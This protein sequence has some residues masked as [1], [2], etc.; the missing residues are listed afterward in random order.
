MTYSRQSLEKKATY[1]PDIQGLRAVAALLVATY[2]IWFGRVSGGV[3]VFFAV[4]AF[5]ITT[6][7]LRQLDTKGRVDFVAFWGGLA[8][9]LLPAAMLVLFTVALAS[10][11][12]LPRTLWDKTIEQMVAS[13]FYVE[14]WQLAHDAVDYLAQGRAASPVQHYW[15]L[16]TQGQ[17]YVLW[18]IVFAVSIAAAA[19]L[20]AK[21]RTIVGGAFAGIFIASF[22]LSIVATRNNQTFT[23][24]NTFARLW[25][26]CLGA[27]LAFQPR[28]TL[29]RHLRVAFGWIGLVGIIVC[30]AIFQVSRVFPG[31]AA[32]WPVGCAVLIV[33]AGPSGSRFGA[34]RLLASR[35]LVYIGGISYGLYLWHWPA[36]VFYRW[37]TDF[38]DVGLVAGLGIVTASMALAAVSTRL[39]ENPLRF[40]GLTLATPGRLAAFV[41][42]GV[43]PSLLVSAAWADYYVR[44]KR[45]DERPISAESAD[46]PGA[47]ALENGFKYAGKSHLPLYPG[48]L[49]VQHDLSAIYTDGCYRPDADWER[50]H[51]VYGDRS[52][53]RTLALV[54]GSHSVH[55]LPALDAIAKKQDWRIVVYTKSNCIF[56]DEIGDLQY[57][58]WCRE[59]NERTLAILLADRPPVIFTTATRG[60]G[61]REHVPEGFLTR[62]RR[63]QAAGIE[64]IAIRDTPWMQFWVPEC[65]DMKGHDLSSCSQA[66]ANVLATTSPLLHSSNRPP[67]VSFIDMSEYFCNDT[68]CPPAI[69]NVI[70]YVDDSHITST[71]SRTL[72]PMLSRKLAA[73]LPEGW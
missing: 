44:Q 34:D 15:A 22:A 3:D 35:P 19:R 61:A 17:I 14:N 1:R 11:I 10:M 36:L 27:W 73:V 47:L 55:W 60:S 2:H 43:I 49:A 58:E 5:L 54:G 42:A 48:M 26:F 41:A 69:G 24:F 18:P 7:L 12:W 4:S 16:S 70:V 46:Y 65:L 25:E 53:A 30:G 50:Q 39:V 32:L 6:S 57:D 33:L 21:P 62:W 64:V 68:T 56:G 20:R 40:S 67:N 23:Y 31:Y 29:N 38:M 8:R 45:Y 51:C 28:V 72:A 37:F 13:I 71:Y 63:L 59:W 9:R 66:R 52:S